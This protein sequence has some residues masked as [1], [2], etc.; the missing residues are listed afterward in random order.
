MHEK[1]TKFV[2][3]VYAW[4]S[5][6]QLEEKQKKLITHDKNNKK[7]VEDIIFHFYL[8]L[9]SPKNDKIWD[10]AIFREFVSGRAS[11]DEIYFYLYV[12]NLLLRG[13]YKN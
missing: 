13:E 2:D 3:F 4:L 6:F 7:K 10:C 9:M 8:D 11:E 5:N 12:R 1:P